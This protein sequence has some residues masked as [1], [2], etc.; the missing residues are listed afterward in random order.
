[1]GLAFLAPSGLA[2]M[3]PS[4][5]PNTA[6][7]FTQGFCSARRLVGL[8]H[9]ITVIIADAGQVRKAVQVYGGFYVAAD[10][11]IIALVKGRRAAR[12]RRHRREI[13]AGTAADDANPFRIDT[14]LIGMGLQIADRGFHIFQ[15]FRE[16]GRRGYSVLDRSDDIARFSQVHAELDA[17]VLVG[18]DEYFSLNF[19]FIVSRILADRCRNL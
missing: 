8:F 1:M 14:E 10:L 5:P 11:E 18:V 2:R 6:D 12:R 16:T 7:S 19:F 9:G 4:W 13:A 15:G 3:P 17:V